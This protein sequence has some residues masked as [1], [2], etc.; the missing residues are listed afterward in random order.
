MIKN[1]SNEKIIKTFENKKYIIKKINYNNSN[2][3]TIISSN[4]KNKI[5]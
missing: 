5:K 3:N 2:E 4:E 1:S